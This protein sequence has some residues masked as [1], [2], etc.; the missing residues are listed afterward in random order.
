[1]VVV[2]SFFGYLQNKSLAVGRRTSYAS[3]C[4]FGY[5]G[6]LLFVAEVLGCNMEGK[7]RSLFVFRVDALGPLIYLW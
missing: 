1:M 4:L 7:D 2:L 5:D 3:V 6:V